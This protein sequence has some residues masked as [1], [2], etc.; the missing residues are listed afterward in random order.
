MI[1]ATLA[2]GQNVPMPPSAQIIKGEGAKSLEL[3]AKRKEREA[4][5]RGG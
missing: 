5:K 1:G 4:R 3:R 2:E